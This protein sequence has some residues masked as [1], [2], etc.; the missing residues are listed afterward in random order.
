LSFFF[1]QGRAMNQ[2]TFKVIPLLFRTAGC[3]SLLLVPT[4]KSPAREY[5]EVSRSCNNQTNRQGFIFSSSHFFVEIIFCLLFLHPPSPWKCPTH[6]CSAIR[7][8]RDSQSIWFSIIDTVYLVS[9]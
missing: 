4:K 7:L 6:V 5:L 1:L 2:S 9:Q 8:E 3:H